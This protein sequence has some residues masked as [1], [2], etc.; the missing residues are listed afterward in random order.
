MI[1]ESAARL[2]LSAFDKKDYDNGYEY[3]TGRRII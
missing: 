2:L 3:D 1:D